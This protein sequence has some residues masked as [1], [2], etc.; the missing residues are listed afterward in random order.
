MLPP[1]KCQSFREIVTVLLFS[2]LAGA[3]ASSDPVQWS[4]S[5]N[6]GD[7]QFRADFAGGKLDACR[8]IADNHF[9]LRF[10]PENTPINHSPWY[11]FAVTAEDE[12]EVVL[13]LTYSTHQHRYW[14]KVSSNGE[15]WRP[16]GSGAVTLADDDGN[17]S[18]RAVVGPSTLWISAQELLDNENYQAWTG[19]LAERTGLE[20]SVLGKSTEGRDIY[21]LQTAQ[22]RERYIFLTGRQ[23]PPEVTGALAMR[24]FVERLYESDAIAREFRG[25]F[26]VLMVPNM[27]PDGVA[28]GY[29]RH[30]VNGVDLN[31]DWGPFTQIETQLVRELLSPFRSGGRERLLLFLDFHSTQHD[32]L[33]TQLPEMVTRPPGFTDNW[34]RGIQAAIL[35]VAPGYPVKVKPGHNPD[36]PT[37]KA[38]MHAQFGIPAITFELGDETDREFIRSYSRI[39]AEQ[40]M[41]ELLRDL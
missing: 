8:R 18:L 4:G 22:K 36:K 37:G 32:V 7:V 9:V 35:D 3:C 1:W 27:N 5:C 12:R 29:W 17:A 13:E 41:I 40:M 10:D 26:G 23:H 6:F 39:A 25:A 15:T 24:H 16:M 20:S 19:Q 34:V 33:Y 38:Y 14:P 11:S 21:L 30:N 2:L 28:K 31:R